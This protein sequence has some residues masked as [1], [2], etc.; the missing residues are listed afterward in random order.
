M[1]YKLS[2]HAK[3]KMKIRQISFESIEEVLNKPQQVFSISDKRKIFQSKIDPEQGKV[4]LLRIIVEDDVK[5]PVVVTIYRTGKIKK[6]W[7]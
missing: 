3:L 6:Y 5:P 7:R 2:S 4:Y 1:K